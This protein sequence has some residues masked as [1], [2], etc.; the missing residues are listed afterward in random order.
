MAERYQNEEEKQEAAWKRKVMGEEFS[1]SLKK[2]CARRSLATLI[3][4]QIRQGILD[5]RTDIESLFFP[6]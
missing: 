1:Y 5:Q 3:G 4:Y 2:G 6:K